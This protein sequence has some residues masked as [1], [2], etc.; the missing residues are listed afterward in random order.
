MCP[1]LIYTVNCYGRT[2]R[3][4]YV[5]QMKT[6]RILMGARTLFCELQFPAK[7]KLTIENL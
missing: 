5:L 3:Q 4:T 7:N 1:C 2:Q 6:F